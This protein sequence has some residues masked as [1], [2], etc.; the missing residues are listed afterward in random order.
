MAKLYEREHM[1]QLELERL[2][3]AFGELL[4]AVAKAD[5][6]VQNSEI[7]R[8]EYMAKKYSWGK[9]VLWSF[10]YE[11]ERDYDL[12]DA[13]SRALGRMLEFGPHPQ[14]Q[15][16]IQLLNQVAE[17]SNGIDYKEKQLIQRFE[18]D[19]VEGLEQRFAS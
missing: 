11:K 17:A 7:S 19:L 12:N 16:L 1:D 8:L 13:Y 14:Y 4:Y 10:N 5:G 6:E 3:D 15:Q 2:F 9:Q 18:R